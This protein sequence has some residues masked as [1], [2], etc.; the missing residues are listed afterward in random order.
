M[1]FQ[2][3]CKKGLFL[4]LNTLIQGAHSALFSFDKL[5]YNIYICYVAGVYMNGSP[6]N[7]LSLIKKNVP[8][9]IIEIL[10]KA[11]ILADR[12]GYKAYLVGGFVRD[13]LL[14]LKSCD[15]DIVIDGDCFEF[16]KILS[17]QLEGRFKKYER[18]LTGKIILSS[19]MSIDIATARTEYYKSPAS[20]PIVERGNI[21]TDMFRR[22]FTINALAISLNKND[23]GNIIDYFNG[24][25]DLNKRILRVIHKNSFNDDPTR[26]FRGIR[27][28]VRYGL[29][30]EKKTNLLLKAAVENGVINKLSSDRLRNEIFL[31]LKEKH[32]EENIKEL[33]LYKIL[34]KLF[35]DNGIDSEIIE[36][37]KSAKHLIKRINRKKIVSDVNENTVLLLILFKNHNFIEQIV[38]RLNLPKKT[39]KDVMCLKE[40]KIILAELNKCNRPSKIYELLNRYS[41]EFI[42]FLLIVSYNFTTAKNIIRYFKTAKDIRL[43]ITGHTLTKMGIKPG[44]KFKMILNQ[45][46]KL[47][48]DGK[49]STKEEEIM[50]VSKLLKK[51]RRLKQC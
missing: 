1:L 29:S 50:F 26:I 7:T 37:I 3:D 15:I 33:L 39:A 41:N 38:S 16:G 36:K 48:L 12:L 11:G 28:K 27:L 19:G 47:K 45:V 35:P 22:D 44:P 18:F 8:K 5:C 9:R 17:E 21:K 34:D 42:V 49:I 25:K 30:F 31:M 2:E 46:R 13:L 24:I 20:L 51:L 14:E 10:F 43:N 32:P 4:L 23:F 6:F 40:Y